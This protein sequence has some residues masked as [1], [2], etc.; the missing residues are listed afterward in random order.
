MKK[1]TNGILIGMGVLIVTF[2]VWVFSPFGKL[3]LANTITNMVQL[4]MALVTT[5]LGFYRSQKHLCSA[6]AARLGVDFTR[7]AV[8][9]PGPDG[10]HLLLFDPGGSA[11]PFRG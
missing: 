3:E 2:T 5:G 8:R 7:I 6:A 10:W 11:F 4:L 9:H 1:T